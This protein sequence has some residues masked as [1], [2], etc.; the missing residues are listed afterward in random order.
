MK[1]TISRASLVAALA[2]SFQCANAQDIHFT[3][4]SASPLIVNPAFTGSG[5]GVWRAAAVYRDQW[6]SVTSPFKTYAVSVDAPIVN[7]LTHD[8][9]LAAGIQ[10]YNDR[11][12][13]ANLS[14]LSALASVAYH[15]F[16]GQ[17]AALSVGFQG[18]YTQ[19]S[20]DLTK[21]Y[22]GNEFQGGTFNPGT[23]GQNLN[24][25]VNYFTFNA[26]IAWAHAPS[27]N[28]SYTIGLG[29]NNINQ[30][31]ESFEKKTHSD[32][33]LGMRYTAQLGIEANLSETFSI[34]PAFLYQTQT[35]A[36]EMVAGNEFHLIVGNPEFR[37]FTTA[38]FLGGYWRS[39]DAIMVN[40]GV[41]F[42]GMRVGVSYD[43]NTSSLKTA[44]NGNGGFEISLIYNAPSALDF[45]RRLVYPCARF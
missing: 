9:N 41:E 32:V 4:F 2:L 20:F 33:G 38:V 14:N 15:K 10:F 36:V 8:D 31:K 22:F 27:Q 44:S 37:N 25:K 39:N 7:D 18:G 11:A 43:Y 35:T 19:K 16:V 6:R 40:A 12:G 5:T 13:D 17:G 42:K 34:R 23:S 26:G 45:A 28:F 21:L 3:Q 1:N 24:N 30:P 29:A